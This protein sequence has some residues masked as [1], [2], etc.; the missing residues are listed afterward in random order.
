MPTNKR[1]YLGW[2]DN[3]IKGEPY[4]EKLQFI[5]EFAAPHISIP[6]LSTEL[7]LSRNTLPIWFKRDEINVGYIE[8]I[9]DILGYT[10]TLYI[11]NNPDILNSPVCPHVP[12]DETP[13]KVIKFFMYEKDHSIP[14]IADKIGWETSRLRKMLASDDLSFS[15][16]LDIAHAFNMS[17]GA[18]FCKKDKPHN[19]IPG[20]EQPDFRWH[21]D[22]PLIP[23][24]FHIGSNNYGNTTE[25]YVVGEE[26]KPSSR[27]GRTSKSTH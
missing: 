17:V 8:K 3:R 24:Y 6:E 15:L 21:I 4:G 1:Q 11:T 18:W 25:T 23:D 14:E 2:K 10:V 19:Y 7:G 22:Y 27:R 5:Y 16:L 26:R 13:M 9:A 20:K 12:G